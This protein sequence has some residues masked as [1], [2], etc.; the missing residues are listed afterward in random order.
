MKNSI[1]K[2]LG[3][4]AAIACATALTMSVAACNGDN[5]N[6]DNGDGG[7]TSYTVTYEYNNGTAATTDTVAEGGTAVRPQD[8]ENGNNVFLGWFKDAEC[9]VPFDFSAE[10]TQNVTVYAAW[11]TVAEG[12]CVATFYMND[13]TENAFARVIFEEGDFYQ[14]ILAEVSTVTWENHYFSGW[15]S[16]E[17][18]T[19]TYKALNSFSENFSVY[20]GWK[21]IYTL[22]AEQTDLTGKAGSGYSGSTTGT[23]M[24]TG[25]N[26]DSLSASNGYYVSWMYYNGA[27]L[28][29]EFVAEEAADDVTIVF[30]LSAQYNDVEVTGDEV[31]VGVNY[32]EDTEQYEQ[33]YDFPF[34][35]ASYPEMSSNVKDFSNYI[36]VE[37]ASVKKGTNTI[38]LVINNN[39]KGVGGTMKAAAPLVDC[40]Y[41]YTN[42]K[43]TATTYNPEFGG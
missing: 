34:T 24:V 2:I 25:D 8:P 35:I 3:V 43:I 37:N 21:L 16:D 18:C 22:E 6:D 7:T 27:Y 31:F 30:R 41:L 33:T 10:I 28:S 40:M 38:E 5:N 14:D 26:T 11:T 29:F 19:Q 20:A 1:K 17:E 13:G 32:N 39:I 15:F 42:A 4:S 36:V 23:G 9:T 12:E